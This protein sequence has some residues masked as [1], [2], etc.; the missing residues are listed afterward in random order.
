ML[1]FAA[2]MN[3]FYEGSWYFGYIFSAHVWPKIVSSVERNNKIKQNGTN[4]PD[5][6]P[7]PPP[8]VM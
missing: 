1:N 6:F 4:R 5:I 7:P 8:V 2:N 3:V